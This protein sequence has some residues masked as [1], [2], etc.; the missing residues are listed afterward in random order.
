MLGRVLELGGLEELVEL[1][2]GE[3]VAHEA[4]AAAR[5]RLLRVRAEAVIDAEADRE[6]EERDDDLAVPL[7][8]E[9]AD[10]VAHDVPRR[11]GRLRLGRRLAAEVVALLGVG[12]RRVLRVEASGG[13]AEREERGPRDSEQQDSERE[14]EPRAISDGVR[15]VLRGPRS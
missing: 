2:L 1:L 4:A 3:E 10:V 9:P 11:V 12:A 8:P 6:A 5:R 13:R 15:T 7:P 14:R